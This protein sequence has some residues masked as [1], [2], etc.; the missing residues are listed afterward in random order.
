VTFCFKQINWVCPKYVKSS[1]R[2]CRKFQ[3][4]ISKLNSLPPKS[5]SFYMFMKRSG[6]CIGGQ[7]VQK[8]NIGGSLGVFR[9]K[10]SDGRLSTL[11]YWSCPCDRTYISLDENSAGFVPKF[12]VHVVT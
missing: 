3:I 9:T 5:D 10:L 4:S 2:L 6:S 8:G 1:L 12:Y 11:F 7:L